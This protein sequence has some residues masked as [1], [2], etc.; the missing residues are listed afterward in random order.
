[1]QWRL[2]VAG[3]PPPEWRQNRTGPT[4]LG[5]MDTRTF[6]ASPV[7]EWTFPG[8]VSIESDD[9]RPRFFYR[10]PT[11]VGVVEGPTFRPRELSS[12]VEIARPDSFT[13]CGPLDRRGGAESDHPDARHQRDQCRNHRDRRT[14]GII[15]RASSVAGL[16]L[17]L[18]ADNASRTLWVAM[19]VD[20]IQTGLGS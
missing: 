7:P 1:M 9:F 11:A 10:T 16:P 3:H 4:L 19:R 13:C 6:G 20:L 12:A 14:L 15:R 8:G 5:V 18:A 17:A 2:P